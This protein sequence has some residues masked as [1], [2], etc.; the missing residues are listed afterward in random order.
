MLGC[1]TYDEARAEQVLSSAFA[2][3]PLEEVGEYVIMPTL[4][5]IGE[6]WHKGAVSITR[7]HYATNYLLQRLAALLRSTPP[8]G[9]GPAIWVGCAPGERHEIGMLLLAIYLRR[10]GYQVCYL[11]QDLLEDDLIQEIS[12]QQPALV[13]FSATST[14]TAANLR[15]L[16]NRLVELGSPR[17]LIGYGGRVFNLHPELRSSIAGVYSGRNGD[18]S[19]ARG[20]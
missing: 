8:W 12:E 11:G 13:L 4:V 20:R 3:Y 18:R 7:E 15:R 2:L 1:S 14:E 10:R 17:P 16:C 5:E 6:R 19:S 9:D